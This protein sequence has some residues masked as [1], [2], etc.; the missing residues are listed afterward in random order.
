MSDS[1]TLLGPFTPAGLP[2]PVDIPGSLL[3]LKGNG[4]ALWILGREKRLQLGYVV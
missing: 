4:E 2:H 1:F 3:F